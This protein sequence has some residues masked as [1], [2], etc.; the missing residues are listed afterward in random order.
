VIIIPPHQSGPPTDPRKAAHDTTVGML[1]VA[2]IMLGISLF[3]FILGP[4]SNNPPPAGVGFAVVGLA[5]LFGL[6]SFF[7]W[8]K[9]QGDDRGD[10]NN[11]NSES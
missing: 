6:I 10:G 5:L 8:M 3:I 4:R 2:L 9:E 7:S 11:S 1:V